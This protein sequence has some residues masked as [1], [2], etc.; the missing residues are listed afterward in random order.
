MWYP[1]CLLLPTKPPPALLWRADEMAKLHN[2]YP[3]DHDVT[4]V[5]AE[6]L[7]VLHPWAMWVKNETSGEIGPVNDSTLLVKT[8]LEEVSIARSECPRFAPDV[9]VA[10]TTWD[11]AT[12]SDIL[13]ALQRC[14]PT[15]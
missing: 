8:V 15:P 10:D 1:V 6:S 9:L 14:T 2:K 5:Y 7:M 3:G 11:E 12:V 4:A 13:P